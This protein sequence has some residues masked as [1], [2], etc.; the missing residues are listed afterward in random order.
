MSAGVATSEGEASKDEKMVERAGAVF[1]P[2]VVETMGVWTPFTKKALKSIA[3]R[4]T[5]RNGL[6]QS[7]AYKNLQATHDDLW[8]VP[9][10]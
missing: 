6:S 3:S 9:F 8:D 4:S 1:V 2:L 10:I 5:I 7:L